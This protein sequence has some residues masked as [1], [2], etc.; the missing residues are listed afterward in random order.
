MFQGASPR[1]V[2]G[3]PTTGREAVGLS[4]YERG[5]V[6]V[7]TIWTEMWFDHENGRSVYVEFD[8]P[9]SSPLSR[10]DEV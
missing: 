8:K 9:E 5:Y 2:A 7:P 6:D 1:T 10:P 4:G 3:D